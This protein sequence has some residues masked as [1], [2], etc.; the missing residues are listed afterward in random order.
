MADILPI[1]NVLNLLIKNKPDL[2]E[3]STLALCIAIPIC[4]LLALI[5]EKVTK[6]PFPVGNAKNR[7]SNLWKWSIR[8]FFSQKISEKLA[9]SFYNQGK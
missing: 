3:M 4:A 2:A 1:K 5:V 9:Q 7:F 8:T 6:N